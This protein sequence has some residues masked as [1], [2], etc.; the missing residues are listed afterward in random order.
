MINLNKGEPWIIHEIVEFVGKNHEPC[1]SPICG[2]YAIHTSTLLDFI[3]EKYGIP[4][5]TL[6]KWAGSAD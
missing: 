3:H 6:G 5:E 4:K 1:P 2:D